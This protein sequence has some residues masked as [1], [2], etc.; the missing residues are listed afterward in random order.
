[1]PPP[2]PHPVGHAVLQSPER[3]SCGVE[4]EDVAVKVEAR[5]SPPVKTPEPETESVR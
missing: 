5:T 4:M 2:V 3:Q 1:M